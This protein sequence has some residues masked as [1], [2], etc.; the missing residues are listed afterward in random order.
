[1]VLKQETAPFEA[2]KA[3]WI[4][5]EMIPFLG[6]VLLCLGI[7]P[8]SIP[9][10]SA[11]ERDDQFENQIRPVLAATCFGCHGAP[12]VSGELRV[13]SREA[14]LKG[15]DSGPS[16]VPGS[17]ETSLL[18]KA[19][20][21]H[22]DVSAMPPDNDKALRP[23]QLAEFEKW[24]REGAYWPATVAP[25][26]RAEHW[27]FKPIEAH[28][29]AR[30]SSTENAIDA[31]IRAKQSAAGASHAPPADKIALIRRAT[32]DLTG[33]PPTTEEIHDFAMD[34]SDDAFAKVVDRLLASQEYG[35]RWGRHWLDVVRYAD[36]AGETADYP[37]PLAWRYRNYVIDSFNADKPYD[38]FIQEQIAGDVLAD[39]AP[40]DRYAE[41][42]TATGYL[43][44]SRRFGFTQVR[45]PLPTLHKARSGI[46]TLEAK[47]GRAS[48]RTVAS[49]ASLN[50]FT[51]TE[52]LPPA[53]PS[54]ST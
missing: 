52:L 46:Y 32:F 35:R 9:S 31:L 43:A 25:F 27:A 38:Q 24:I 5:A 6:I 45:S 37:V 18:M 15:G 48:L 12:K 44:I 17:P 23:E 49:T 19:I 13:D 41:Q 16:I 53:H 20:Q 40:R 34:H 33:L 30:T 26:E 47:L 14:L 1:M 3:S 10:V 36:T 28:D 4:N 7:L 29:P 21:R 39:L 22:D 50:R 8:C 54:T 42:V 51:R 2:T 11:D